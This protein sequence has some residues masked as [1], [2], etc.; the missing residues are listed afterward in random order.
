MHTFVYLYRQV[1]RE[2]LLS[3][4]TDPL[5]LSY[6]FLLRAYSITQGYNNSYKKNINIKKKHTEV[7]PSENYLNKMTMNT[8]FIVHFLEYAFFIF[9]VEKDFMN[10]HVFSLR[11]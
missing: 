10:N 5:N 11:G 3:N 7:I 2:S 9:R 4:F 1:I 8:L 6:L